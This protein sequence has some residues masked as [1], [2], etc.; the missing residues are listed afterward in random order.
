MGVWRVRG[1]LSRVKRY[2]RRD[3]RA[4]VGIPGFGEDP[5]TATREQVEH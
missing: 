2:G 3:D 5:D 4:R 1:W